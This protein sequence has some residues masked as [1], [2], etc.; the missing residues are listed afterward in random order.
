MTFTLPAEEAAD[1]LK[2]AD[3][4]AFEL[5]ACAEEI[6]SAHRSSAVVEA[7]MANDPV[8]VWTRT[9]EVDE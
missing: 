5:I 2:A 1:L 8:V 9:Q 4:G 7:E 3:A 6:V